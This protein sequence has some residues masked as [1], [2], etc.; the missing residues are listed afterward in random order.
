VEV[1]VEV[2]VKN[3]EHTHTHTQHT[4]TH[5]QTLFFA[6]NDV[7]VCRVFAFAIETFRPSKVAKP[8]C[9]RKE[10]AHT[11]LLLLLSETALAKSIVICLP[12]CVSILLVVQVLFDALVA[13]RGPHGGVAGV[14]KDKGSLCIVPQANVCV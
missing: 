4:H 8:N 6:R 7:V 11:V 9:I 12:A 14:Q 13:P 2:E 1:E 10:N 5:T 3:E